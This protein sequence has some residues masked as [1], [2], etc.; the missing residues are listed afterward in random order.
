MRRA[1]PLMRRSVVILLKFTR[2]TEHLHPRLR[3]GFFNYFSLL[4]GLSLSQEE[5]FKHL[6]E[7]GQQA[8]LDSEGYGKLRQRIFEKE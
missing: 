6:D 8:G 2:L 7:L 1:E 5:I 4:T 3:A